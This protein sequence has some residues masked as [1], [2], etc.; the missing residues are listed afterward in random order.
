MPNSTN[1]APTPSDG[2]NRA[3]RETP[4][5]VSVGSGQ[6][7]TVGSGSTPPNMPG[8]QGVSSIR[9]ESTGERGH[10]AR[11]TFPEHRPGVEL[12]EQVLFKVSMV[13]LLT[14]EDTM[15]LRNHRAIVSE[16]GQVFSV[17]SRGYQLVSHREAYEHGIGVF[18]TTFGS[19]ASA[20]LKI[21]NVRTPS[22]GAWVEI[23]LTADSLA[24]SPLQGDR[25]LP[26]LRVMNSYDRSRSL[27]FQLGLCRWICKNGMILGRW[28]ATFR[29]RH[30]LPTVEL[31][32]RLRMAID[33][34]NAT[35]D[36]TALKGQ[37]EQLAKV[38]VPRDAFL[39]GCLE[40][41][42]IRPPTD[43]CNHPHAADW[44]ALGVHLNQL[45]TQYTSELGSNAYALVNAASE[46]AS[47]TSGPLVRAGRIHAL[48]SR[49]GE[50][51][52]EVAGS[53]KGHVDFA[54]R[55]ASDAERL[56]ALA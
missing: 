43:L 44:R 31:P 40:I 46:Y 36:L 42:Q 28:S 20:E 18:A 24:F 35:M 54:K 27:G 55:S 39:P 5:Q 32:A 16:S 52:N 48:Q 33:D 17:V 10:D 41:L 2:F 19:K 25:W 9:T 21:F 47:R 11:S 12:L 7:R 37:L 22:S 1:S 23:D 29:T 45:A 3:D 38:S 34:Q 30:R 51:A 56:M 13:D 49:C 4:T 8:R 14:A 53:K 6:G 15:L 50:W 26:F